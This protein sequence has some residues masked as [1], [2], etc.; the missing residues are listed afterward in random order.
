MPAPA[1]SAM[2]NATGATAAMVPIDVP[3]AVAMKAEIRKIPGRIMLVGIAD[4]P[5]FTVASIANLDVEIMAAKAP[6][7]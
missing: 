1:E 4:R 2:P 6:R 5:R 3:I 7:Q